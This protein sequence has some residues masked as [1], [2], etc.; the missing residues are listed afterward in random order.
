[1]FCTLNYL[2]NYDFPIKQAR[3]T[4]LYKNN[5]ESCFSRVS[6]ARV[7]VI[8]RY[9]AGK[10]ELVHPSSQSRPSPMYILVKCPHMFLKISS[11][12]YTWWSTGNQLHSIFKFQFISS[13]RLLSLVTRPQLHTEVVLLLWNTRTF[14]NVIWWQAAW[15]TA[16]VH[17]ILNLTPQPLLCLTGMRLSACS[18]NDN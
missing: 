12:G 10:K 14:S 4:C 9:W 5:L 7:M 18:G 3:I 6:L 2:R 16:G 17:C 1:M 8:I 11:S 13:E 15:E